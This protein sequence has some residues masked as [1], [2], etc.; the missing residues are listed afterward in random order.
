MRNFFSSR[1]ATIETEF[2]EREILLKSEMPA[3]S[4]ES[5]AS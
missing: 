4:I 3:S 2:V 5:A 1:E